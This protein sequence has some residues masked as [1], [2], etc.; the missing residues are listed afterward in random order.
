M[1]CE[2]I[3]ADNNGV[4]TIESS[5]ESRG[6]FELSDEVPDDPVPES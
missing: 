5:K 2:E 4:I 3:Y 1:M 6:V